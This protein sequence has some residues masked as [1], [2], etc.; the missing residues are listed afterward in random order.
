MIISKY[1]IANLLLLVIVAVLGFRNYEVWTHPMK[2]VP[3]NE[4][5]KGPEKKP[6]TPP[7][8]KEGQG[9]KSSVVSF[10]VIAEKNIFSHE[11]KDF[12]VASPVDINAVVRP[13]V[14]PQVILNGLTI[15][16][17]Y[18][19]AT[20]TSPGKTLRKGEREATTL[21]I[22]EKV[23]EYSLAK[24]S[25]DRIT[26]ENGNDSFEVLLYDPKKPKRRADARNEAKTPD[27][28]F[29]PA[30]AST[31][32]GALPTPLASQASVEKPGET[33]QTQA[34]PLPLPPIPRP[35]ASSF[36]RRGRIPDYPSRS[37]ILRGTPPNERGSGN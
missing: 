27:A 22:G 21:K 28:A 25:P 30:A 33:V 9:E 24:V 37:T 20:I 35:A 4:T 19:A 29:P 7:I 5:Y 34:S 16:E 11:R 36:Q 6:E 15:S 31:D 26:L 14:R 23:G 3:R 17:D 10:K 2:A 18:Q 8:M 12:P 13:K 1:T 32:P